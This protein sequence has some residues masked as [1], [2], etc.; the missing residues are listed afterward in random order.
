MKTPLKRFDVWI[1]DLNPPNGSE[2]GK[3]RPVVI[4]Q[5]DLLNNFHPS[6]LVCPLTTNV[7]PGAEIL[8]VNLAKNE[9]G[10]KKRSSV[11]VDQVRAIDNKRLLK[12]SG[13]LSKISKL[14]LMSN[15]KTIL[16]LD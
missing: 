16:D 12:K 13:A 1:A 8:R 15:L 11:L 9:G 4:V 2:P 5:T 6:T 7:I 14:K 10:L 3:I